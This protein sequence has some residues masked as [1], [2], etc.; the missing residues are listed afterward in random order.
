VLRKRQA[1]D[2][3]QTAQYL[4]REHGHQVVADNIFGAGSS[5]AS[6]GSTD[7]LSRH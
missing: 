4:L 5:P 1:N 3:V 2:Q 7:A 6:P